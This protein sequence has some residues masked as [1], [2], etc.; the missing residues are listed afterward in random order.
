MFLPNT[1]FGA[2]SVMKYGCYTLLCWQM[3]LYSY[4]VYFDCMYNCTCVNSLLTYPGDSLSH[5]VYLAAALPPGDGG[6][7]PRADGLTLH[8]IL[9]IG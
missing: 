3:C 1:L 5:L 7:R 4:F 6:L 8:L 2:S 9:L